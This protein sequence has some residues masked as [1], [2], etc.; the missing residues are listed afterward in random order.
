MVADAVEHEST[1]A[2]P[3]TA[4]KMAPADTVSTKAA[5]MGTTWREIIS[6]EKRA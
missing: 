3:F 5:A 6:A 2:V 4:P 1:T